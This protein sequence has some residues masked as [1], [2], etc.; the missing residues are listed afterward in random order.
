MSKWFSL[1]VMGNCSE[2][3]LYIILVSWPDE[4]CEIS[5]IIVFLVVFPENLKKKTPLFSCFKNIINCIYAPWECGYNSTG[6]LS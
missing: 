1:L 4:L 2:K 5:E 6:K 3:S